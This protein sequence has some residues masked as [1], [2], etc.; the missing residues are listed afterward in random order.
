MSKPKKKQQN[1]YNQGKQAAAK[2][3]NK[4]IIF[5]TLAIVAV[6]AVIVLGISNQNKPVNFEYE[7]LPM[8]GSESA[9]VKIVEFGDYKCPTCQFF[10]QN[11]K[12]QLDKDFIE[13]GKA[14]LYFV[15]YPFIGRDSTTAALAAE[16]VHQQNKEAFWDYYKAIYDHQQDE[17]IA[18]ATP[19]YLVQL[20]KDANLPIDYDKLKSD[21]DN[22]T[23]E[24]QVNRDAALVRPMNVQG[25]PTL[26]INGKK[27]EGPISY[28]AIK[29]AIDKELEGK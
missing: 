8:L 13:M 25:T 14:S 16:A 19:D 2:A 29:S 20:A 3:S 11:I 10:A 7:A 21:I 22:K 9:P 6:V 28:E 26:F 17:R 4:P 15:N 27:Y 5:L 1:S 23:Y 24:K 12:P 18:W